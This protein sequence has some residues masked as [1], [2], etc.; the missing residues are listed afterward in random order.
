MVTDR[1]VAT[2]VHV[3]PP[4]QEHLVRR[5]L[6][7]PEA[8][9][10]GW[11]FRGARVL[12]RGI[13][14]AYQQRST[15]AVATLALVHPSAAAD[16]IVRT[17]R[18]AIVARSASKGG[19]TRELAGWIARSL[20]TGEAAFAWH[21][22]E[23]AGLD[24][25]DPGE[26]HACLQAC[27]P[28]LRRLLDAI[29]AAD[30][31]T[32]EVAQAELFACLSARP[33][34]VM[35]VL[36]GA[37][38]FGALRRTNAALRWIDDG[39]T[40][41]ARSS[42][43]MLFEEKLRVAARA[44]FRDEALAAVEALVE[45]GG[46]RAAVLDLAAAFFSERHD[47]ERAAR[48]AQEAVHADAAHAAHAAQILAAAGHDAE[49]GAT[50]MLALQSC[51]DPR[52]VLRAARAL[53]VIGDFVGEEQ[54]LNRVLRADTARLPALLRLAQLALWRGCY[55]DADE[56]AAR[57]LDLAPGDAAALRYR[58]ASRLLR[59]QIE[60][61]AADLERSAAL[62][63][64]DVETMVLRGELL[65]RLGR[66]EEALAILRRAQPGA[67]SLTPLDFVSGVIAAEAGE[68]ESSYAP[69]MDG[70]VARLPVSEAVLDRLGLTTALE[71][72]AP[73][74]TLHRWLALLRGNRSTTVTT[75]SED[76]GVV[77]LRDRDNA[78]TESCF[79]QALVQTRSID[80]VLAYF[81]DVVARHSDKP[82]PRCY[83]GELLVWLGRYDEA[84]QDF[85]SALSMRSDT[86]WAYVGLGAVELLQGRPEG[87]IETLENGI[88]MANGPGPTTF[89]YRGEAHRLLGHHE[90]A[91][92]DLS[93][94]CR[95]APLRTGAWINLALA[96][97]ALGSVE[98]QARIFRH[99]HELA[100]GL[101]ME[102]CA[103]TAVSPLRA[104]S[105]EEQ[106]RVLERARVMLRG[107]RS[108]TL[109][110]WFNERGQLRAVIWERGDPSIDCIAWLRSAIHDAVARAAPAP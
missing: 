21:A 5:L 72:E 20:R 54:A 93:H 62:D 15:G 105:T 30:V 12:E 22:V 74:Q 27:S 79:A 16:P 82:Y 44:G 47:H 42:L 68:W 39:V 90:E 71:T 78:R 110:T 1:E 87:A 106:R 18:F 41:V 102:A 95:E 32:V 40:R 76:R 98:E 61:A 55:E 107:N 69:F 46:D 25:L 56:H 52:E 45:A 89:A 104:A 65:G 10:N 99:L 51:T 88:R 60:Q 58:G 6:D 53:R 108:S 100:P 70:Y 28:A 14:A 43:L 38:A 59:G 31:D 91:I 8:R 94:A 73:V 83:R 77:A 57:A 26:A 36:L 48:L 96:Q 29:A 81:A 34:S 103:E 64:D 50:A 63:P 11:L 24:A 33:T 80:E 35:A 9:A 13:E 109:G 85:M 3:I 97:G 86:R 92:A 7:S 75:F 84:R 23:Q 49:A 17:D 19:A 4:G 101:V 66:R 37:R 2:V 67:G